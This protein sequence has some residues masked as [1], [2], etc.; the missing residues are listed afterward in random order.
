MKLIKFSGIFGDFGENPKVWGYIG[1]GDNK[2]FGD[3]LGF[4]SEKNRFLGMG[5]GIEF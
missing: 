2:N 1:D 5:T 4:I 3:I